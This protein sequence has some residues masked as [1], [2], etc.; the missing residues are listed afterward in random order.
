MKFTEAID[1][2]ITDAKAEGRINSDRTE[3]SYRAALLCHAEDVGNRDPAKTGRDDVKV[4]LARYPHPNTRRRNHSMLASFY[5]W[6]VWEGIR[7]DNPADQVRPAKTRKPQVYRLTFDETQRFLLSARG[8]RERRVAF[9]GV[10]AGLRRNELRLL[11]GRHL[12]RDGY[13][14]VSPDIGKG[15]R[16]RY[17]PIMPDLAPIV[18][19]IRAQVGDDEYVLPPQQFADPPFNRRP[20]DS[21]DEPGDG[22]TIWRL[23]KRIGKRAGIA[24]ATKPHTMRHA[25]ADHVARYAGVR[26]AQAMLGHADIST[27]QLYLSEALLDDL[28]KSIAGISFLGSGLPPQKHPAIPLMETVGI[29]PTDSVNRVA[30]PDSDDPDP[31]L[32]A[33]LGA[34]LA[35]FRRSPV[36]LAAARSMA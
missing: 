9:L 2:Y 1:R 36:V 24:A 8:P 15:G 21:V 34:L 35:R 26:N 14:W 7:K 10:C 4:T 29:E 3:I 28:A 11:Q 33:R 19:E 5:K 12:K 30:E 6:T 31:E 27:T 18:E 25:F 23:A 20:L 32:V 17:V 13:V 16:E 22:K